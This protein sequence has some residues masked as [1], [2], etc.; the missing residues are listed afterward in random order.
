MSV[1]VCGC[2]GGCN[3]SGSKSSPNS[4]PSNSSSS[5][6]LALAAVLGRWGMSPS[7]SV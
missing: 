7:G 2:V 6:G 3:Y 1:W 4:T 5:A